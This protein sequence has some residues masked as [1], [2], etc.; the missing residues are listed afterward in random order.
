MN[1]KDDLELIEIIR[2]YFDAEEI[3]IENMGLNEDSSCNII[4]TIRKVHKYKDKKKEKEDEKSEPWYYE[5]GTMCE[6]FYQKDPFAKGEWI[7]G[8]I[9][10]GDRYKDG[11]ITIQW[12]ESPT[13]ILWVPEARTEL[14]R[15]V[16]E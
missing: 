7:K 14:Y 2:E 4:V 6:I 15:K 8:P 9:I 12:N 1:I 16:E 13:G 3:N 10:A 5:L 11:F